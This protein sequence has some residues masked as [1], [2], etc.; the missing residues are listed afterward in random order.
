MLPNYLSIEVLDVHQDR[1]RNGMSLE[2]PTDSATKQND[3]VSAVRYFK[4]SGRNLQKP[5]LSECSGKPSL[6]V[7]H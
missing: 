4:P 7:I 5:R 2:T 1:F 6:P 3:T